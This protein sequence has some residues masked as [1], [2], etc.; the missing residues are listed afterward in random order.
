MSSS[1]DAVLRAALAADEFRVGASD[2]MP[3]AVG[4]GSFP[5]GLLT[6]L[7]WGETSLD[8]VLVDILERWP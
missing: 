6:Y 2:L 3:P 1:Q 5:R 8:Q 4:S 7:K